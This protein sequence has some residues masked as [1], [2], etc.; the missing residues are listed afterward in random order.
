MFDNYEIARDRAQEYFL[1][2]DQ[3]SVIRRWQLSCDQAFL[4][5]DFLGR[6]YRVCRRTGQITRVFDGK[7]AGFSE[8][9][10]IFDFLCHTGEDQFLTGRLAPVNSLKHS[11]K[12]G[13]V[14]TGFYTKAA[15]AFDKD[16]QKLIS[17][18]EALGGTRVDMGDIG[19]RIPLFG[20]MQVVLKFY[21]ADEEFPPSVTF[22]WD[23]NTLN[24]LFY[25]TV[26]YIAG[27]LVETLCEL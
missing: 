10:S 20:E 26:F 2:F 23:E 17:A 22:L 18:C 16:P 14:E 25:E 4:Y 8:V 19:Y 6:P 12:A 15:R 24:F 1:T 5:V 11:P 21:H 27:F 9:L 7:Q 3:D 13:G